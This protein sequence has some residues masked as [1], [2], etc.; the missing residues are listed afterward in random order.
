MSTDSVYIGELKY[1]LKGLSHDSYKIQ[2]EYINYIDNKKGHNPANA[3]R[4]LNKL[5]PIVTTWTTIAGIYEGLTG[6]S[7]HRDSRIYSIN[8]WTD[9]SVK[10]F[11]SPPKLYEDGILVGQQLAETIKEAAD[12][13]SFAS[14]VEGGSND[15]KNENDKIVYG[16]TVSKRGGSKRG[17]SKRGGSKRGMKG[18]APF[19][20][21][22][23]MSLALI[24]GLG[25]IA[26]N[27]PGVTEGVSMAYT[28]ATNYLIRLAYG[29]RVVREGCLT[30]SANLWNYVLVSVTPR[31][32]IKSCVEIAR[33]NEAALQA[34]TTTV[35]VG[36]T[37]VIAF[38]NTT[39]IVLGWSNITSFLDFMD[40]RISEPL[41]DMIGASAV[42]VAS[43]VSSLA[44]KSA[45]TVSSL[46][47]R[48]ASATMDGI[49]TA[50]VVCNEKIKDFRSYFKNIF[51][52]PI[53]R[54]KSNDSDMP[55]VKPEA[56]D[57][58]NSND[59]TNDAENIATAFKDSIEAFKDD[60]GTS[61]SKPG[62]HLLEGIEFTQEQA[63]EAAAAE[64]AARASD[65]PAAAEEEEPFKG[66]KKF[67]KR[68]PKNKTTKSRKNKKNKKYRQTKQKR[69][70]S[71]KRYR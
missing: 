29:M 7:T 10:G 3:A 66:G 26:Y 69:K 4:A 47:S 56:E 49:G 70:S 11:E 63:A 42:S 61:L 22:R 50:L 9:G 13:A 31:D 23:A 37:S 43:T 27:I 48:S 6:D 15:A 5:L 57:I 18:G 38:L 58:T 8:T 2:E 71:R 64:A 28:E 1:L 51:F 24:A 35:Q 60:I 52:P 65:I 46:A 67:T 44:S 41:C 20:V 45:S 39:G 53:K 62:S 14:G 16:F 21:K 17:G 59:A 55:L 68:K 33:E 25:L 34:I 12:I 54:Q 19:Y 32:T 36:I 30:P 40:T